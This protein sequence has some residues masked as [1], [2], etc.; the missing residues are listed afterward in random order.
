[1]LLHLKNQGYSF[2]TLK[3]ISKALKFLAKNCNLNNPENVKNFIADYNSATSY[4]KNLCYAYNHYVKY[5]RL[6]WNKPN[7]K[8]QERLPKIPTEEKINMIISASP[9]KLA[10]KLSISKETGLRPVEVVNLRVRDVDL[11][12]GLIYP[13]TAKHGSGRVLKISTKTL[14]MLKAIIDKENLGLNCK[15]F[16]GSSAHY[17]KQF[18]TVRNR[19]AKK[20][21]DPTIKRIRLYDLRHFYATMLYHKTRDI[22]FVKQQMG[23]RKIETTLMYTQLINFETDEYHVKTAKTVKEACKLIEAGFEYVTD[24]DEVKIFRKRK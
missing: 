10:T 9:F 20:L 21:C 15:I 13:A 7:Y 14:N 1:V 24:V 2:D 18:R 4:K 16:N 17:G 23:H 22:L 3:N 19:I 5:H 12:K 11:E 6:T 8:P